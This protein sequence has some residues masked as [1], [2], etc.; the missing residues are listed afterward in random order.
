MKKRN[1]LLELMKNEENIEVVKEKQ[2]DIEQIFNMFAV[3][4]VNIHNQLIEQSEIEQSESYYREQYEQAQLLSQN[5]YGWIEDIEI[6]TRLQTDV[7]PEDSV[8][9]TSLPARSAASKQSGYSTS[10]SVK[11][12]LI[13][14]AANRMALEAKLELL[15][16][17]QALAERRLQLQKERDEEYMRLQQAEEHLTVESELAQCVV[18]EQV[19]AKAEAADQGQ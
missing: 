13:E 18:R 11:I 8:S 12:R 3:A 19:F 10:S 7:N 17:K 16:K 14:E 2:N 4:Q 5:V 6:K 1:E 9:Q 15:H